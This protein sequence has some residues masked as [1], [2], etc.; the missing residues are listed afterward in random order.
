MMLSS[1]R[2]DFVVFGRQVRVLAILDYINSDGFKLAFSLSVGGAVFWLVIA[3]RP[4]Q[5]LGGYSSRT[6]A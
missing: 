2:E 1:P 4:T 6:P 5:S 3:S